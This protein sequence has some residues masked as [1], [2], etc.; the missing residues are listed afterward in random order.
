[1]ILIMLNGYCKKVF[2]IN[3][4]RK[5]YKDWEFNVLGVDNYNKDGKLKPYY[6]FIRNNHDS[7]EGDICEIGV[8]RGFSLLAT[9]ML[10][11][12]IGSKKIVYGYDS[13]IGFPDYHFNDDLEK[14]ED[15]YSKGVISSDHYNDFVLNVG[16]KSLVTNVKI[17]P[18]NIS[19]SGDFSDNSLTL[20]EK[21]IEFLELDNITLVKG[22]FKDTMTTLNIGTPK[23]FFAG[24]VDCDLY[25]G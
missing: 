15:L 19:S 21:K 18:T 14:F 16:Y 25:M 3:D 4:M 2:N 11:K 22:D 13:F 6:E 20:L 17:D 8:Y 7:I 9:A 5:L 24:L 23:S 12:E 1:M 10:L